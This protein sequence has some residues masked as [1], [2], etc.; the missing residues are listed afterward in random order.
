M[1]S[2]SDYRLG[3]DIPMMD[4]NGC[5]LALVWRWLGQCS[6][7]YGHHERQTCGMTAWIGSDLGVT[8]G[9]TNLNIMF[10]ILQ[11]RMYLGMYIWGIG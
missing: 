8:A 9:V 11:H 6:L 4:S 5:D 2:G 7:L 3:W 1:V 10:V